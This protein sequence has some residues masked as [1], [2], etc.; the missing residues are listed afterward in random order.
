MS[1]LNSFCIS[2]I[3]WLY[4]KYCAVGNRRRPEL[5]HG[6]VMLVCMFRT[7]VTCVCIARSVS[8]FA[9]SFLLTLATPESAWLAEVTSM[10]ARLSFLRPAQLEMLTSTSIAEDARVG[11]S[12]CG[13]VCSESLLRYSACNASW[14]R[15]KSFCVSLSGCVFSIS[16]MA[17]SAVSCACMFIF[18]LL[19]TCLDL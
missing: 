2:D 4:L 18:I 6:I 16:A 17:L 10:E 11:A 13:A 7:A 3:A 8:E 14:S 12:D 15:M 19:C 1:R 9:S 5:D